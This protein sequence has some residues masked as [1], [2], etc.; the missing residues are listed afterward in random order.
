MRVSEYQ[1]PP[2]F[3]NIQ[4]ALQMAR[5]Q[6]VNT[7]TPNRQIMF[8]HRRIAHG[9]L[10]GL[11][12]L[13]ALPARPTNRSRNDAGRAEM[14]QRRDHHQYLLDTQLVAKRRRYSSLPIG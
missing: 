4:H 11:D 3:T 1:I 10:R 14:R 8:D 6:L 2:H 13:H 5:Q 12:A 9:A 7:D